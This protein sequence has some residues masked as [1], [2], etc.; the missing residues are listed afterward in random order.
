MSVSNNNNRYK[1]EL[2]LAELYISAKFDGYDALVH[3]KCSGL[4]ACELN[5]LAL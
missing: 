1:F 2:F 4:T 3:T 5:C